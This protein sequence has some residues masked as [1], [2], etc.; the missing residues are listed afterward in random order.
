MVA[1]SASSC[2]CSASYTSFDG[3]HSCTLQLRGK[4]SIKK[5]TPRNSLKQG[6]PILHGLL[7]YIGRQFGALELLFGIKAD[8]LDSFARWCPAC[9]SSSGTETSQVVLPQHDGRNSP[10]YSGG[11]H[12]VAISLQEESYYT[13]RAWPCSKNGCVVEEAR[14]LTSSLGLA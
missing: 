7:Q 10:R 14:Q 4:H 6:C 11:G 2:S 9:G 12:L 1:L 8:N 13:F 3:N 5:P